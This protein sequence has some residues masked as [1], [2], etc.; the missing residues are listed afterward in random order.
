MNAAEKCR[1]IWNAL[2]SLFDIKNP[3]QR[4]ESTRRKIVR[5]YNVAPSLS[6][7]PADCC[8]SHWV[9]QVEHNYSLHTAECKGELL[10]AD[11]LITL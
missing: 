8:T 1:L 9:M 4:L 11:C 5:T 2:P 6:V 7:L 10:Q 3:P